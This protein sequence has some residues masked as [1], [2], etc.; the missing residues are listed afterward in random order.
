MQSYE[1]IIWGASSAAI[2]KAIEY[3]NKGINTLLLNKFGFPGG[4]ATEALNAF[5]NPSADLYDSIISV[6]QNFAKGI[7][8]STENNMLLH[9]E[10]IKRAEW[11][12][13]L[14]HFVNYLFHVIPLQIKTN[15]SQKFLEVYGREGKFEIEYKTLI[16]LSDDQYLLRTLNLEIK[17]I[18]GITI[19]LFLNSQRTDFSLTNLN[20][21]TIIPTSVGVFVRLIL[22]AD[23]NVDIQF[24]NTLNS[25]IALLWEKYNI[26]PLLIPSR[27]V[28][29]FN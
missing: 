8:Q 18:T 22:P 27:P 15:E 20:F 3:K 13:M 16:D 23:S 24:N 1:V 28:Y 9:P 6:A 21:E 7:L 26:R 25:V 14:Q 10:S 12:I 4:D 29:N 11:E 19:C 17:P 2:A 5:I